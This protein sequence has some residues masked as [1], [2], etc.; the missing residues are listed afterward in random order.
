MQTREKHFCPLR[1]LKHQENSEEVVEG[2]ISLIIG[3]FPLVLV[4]PNSPD[5]MM[6]LLSCTITRL[7]AVA[8]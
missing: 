4:A 7:V 6:F 3:S 8:S 2:C 5:V 1:A